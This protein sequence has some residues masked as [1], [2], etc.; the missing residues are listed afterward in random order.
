[1]YPKIAEYGLSFNGKMMDFGCGHK[2]YKS[3]FPHVEQYIGVDYANQGHSHD[4]EQI[5]VFYDGHSLPFSDNYFDCAICTEVLEH[6]PNIDESL[7]LLNRVLKKDAPVILTVPFVWPEHEMPFDFRRFTEGGIVQKLKEHGFETHK[8]HKNGDYFSVIAELQIM[9]LHRLLFTKQVYLNLFM[10]AIFVF[11]FTLTGV[12][13]S[14]VFADKKQGS[15][16]ALYFNSI[17]LAS[18]KV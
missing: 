6:V 4:K 17:L 8:V 1:M 9:F 13:L 10:N 15:K 16:R 18:K 14:R 2:P 3:L 5:D 12:I 11:P 7:S